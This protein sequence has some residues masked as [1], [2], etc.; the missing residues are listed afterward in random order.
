MRRADGEAAVIYAADKVSKV[1]EL[2]MMMAR[3]PDDPD[4]EVRLARY[5]R[6]LEMLEQQIPGSRLVELLRFELEALEAMPPQRI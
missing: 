2:R 4:I 1:R 5:R 3:D 6:S